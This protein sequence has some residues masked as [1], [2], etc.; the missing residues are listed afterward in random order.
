MQPTELEHYL[1]EQ[2]PLVRAMEIAVAEVNDAGVVLRAPLA[3]N[4]NHFNTAFG[5]SVAA[6]AILAAWSLLYVRLKAAGCAARIVVRRTTIEYEQAIHH[7]F[8]ARASAPA[9]EEWLAFTRMFDRK[10]KARITLT[11]TLEDPGTP[12]ARFTGDFVA[13][14]ARTE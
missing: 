10:G 2:I 13:T 4:R 9:E 5:G 1:R 7:D 8:I 14:L 12:A 11:A 3:P 6:V